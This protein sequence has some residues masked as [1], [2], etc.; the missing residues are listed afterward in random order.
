MLEFQEEFLEKAHL[1]DGEDPGPNEQGEVVTEVW[2]NNPQHTKNEKFFADK[3]KDKDET[4]NCNKI[5]P[6]AKGM[7][8]GLAHITCHH[9]ITKGYSAYPKGEG[10]GLFTK[11]LMKRLPKHVKAAK[12]VF[13]YDNNCNTH[14]Y[15][16][17]RYPWRCRRWTFVIDRVHF[18]NHKNCSSAYNMDSY[19]WLDGINSQVCEQ[20]N[21]SLRKMS[22][23][24]AYMSFQNYLKTLTLFF[25]YTNLKVKGNVVSPK[26][27]K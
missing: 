6:E 19:K 15:L 17:R 12:R 3:S 4:E 7:T 26:W 5:Y 2:P 13:I 20:K 16:M 14:K 11:P 9:G 22:T 18:K 25:T 21:N 23:S 8:G 24:L 10:Q 1:C 27:Q